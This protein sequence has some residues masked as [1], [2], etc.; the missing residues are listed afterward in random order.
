MKQAQTGI[1]SNGLLQRT[2]KTMKSFVAILL[3]SASHVNLHLKNQKN[4]FGIDTTERMPPSCESF[5]VFTI[6][7]V[8]TMARWNKRSKNSLNGVS[9][10]VY[11][12]LSSKRD[13]G[14][15]VYCEDAHKRVQFPAKCRFRGETSTE[16]QGCNSVLVSRTHRIPQ[17]LWW[18]LPTACIS[19]TNTI[20]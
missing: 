18:V 13:C 6:H 10:S 16:G 11:A 3:D 5:V 17:W 7:R 19:T 1:Y 12:L 4:S 8:K 14:Q 15:S 2:Q 20:R 9:Q